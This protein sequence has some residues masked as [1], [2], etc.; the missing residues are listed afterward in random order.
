V[1]RWISNGQVV[2]GGVHPFSEFK[3]RAESLIPT[4]AECQ[5]ASPLASAVAKAWDAD[6]TPTG[7]LSSGHDQSTE[8]FTWSFMIS[9]G[10]AALCGSII[11]LLVVGALLHKCQRS[12][13]EY[14]ELDTVGS[15]G[16]EDNGILLSSRSL[17]LYSG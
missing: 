14:A 17:A 2:H 16:E 1:T 12:Y 13:V 3:H 7:F 4:K 9:L 6:W 11:T 10:F 8:Q 5:Q 15:S